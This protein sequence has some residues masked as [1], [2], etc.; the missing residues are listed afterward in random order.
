MNEFEEKEQNISS[1]PSPKKYNLTLQDAIE[2][3]ECDPNY[4]QNFPE[5]HN[6]TANIQWQLIR[7]ALNI[8]R[9]QLLTHWSELNSALDFTKK[10]HVQQALRNVERQLEKLRDDQERLY[11]EYSSKI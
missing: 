1:K 7:K 6:L 2:F 5:W 9:K 4:L 8:R 3:G 10:P 11:V